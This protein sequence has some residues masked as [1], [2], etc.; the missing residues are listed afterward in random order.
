MRFAII[1]FIFAATAAFAVESSL[2]GG[3]LPIQT[4]APDG[5]TTAKLTV[6]S[7]TVD[8]SSNALY[9]VFGGATTCRVRTMPSS[10]KSGVVSPVRYQD[11]TIRAKNPATPYINFT[12]CKN[13]FW[14]RQ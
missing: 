10:T 6:N 2:V 11:W 12:G 1:A 14:Q 3:N 4:F 7:Q 5:T 13:G 8:I 9:A